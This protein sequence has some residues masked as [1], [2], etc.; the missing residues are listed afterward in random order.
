MISSEGGDE[1]VQH[2]AAMRSGT[3]RAW[4]LGIIAAGIF[5]GSTVAAAP[6]AAAPT[7]VPPEVLKYVPVARPTHIAAIPHVVAAGARWEVV[8]ASVD[9]QD[10]IVGAPDGGLFI[11]QQDSDSVR[12]IAP[13]G[14]QTLY[15]A[16]TH[17]AGALGMGTDHRLWAVQRTAEKAITIVGPEPR[18][19]ARSLPD[20]RPLGRLSDIVVDSAGG[21]WI[22]GSFYYVG[23]D[24]RVSTLP[25]QDIQTNGIALSPDGKTLYVTNETEVIAFDVRPGGATANRRVFG[26]LEGDTSADGMGID[27]AGRVYVCAA[28]GIHV[29]SPE[30]RPLGVI[31]TSTHPTSVAFAGPGKKTLYVVEAGALKSDG[32]ILTPAEGATRPA[33]TLYKLSMLAEGFEGRGK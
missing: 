3:H 30:G 21:A 11:A 15:A 12:K 33:R 26:S 9:L 16:N 7:D 19:I 24:G 5:S 23:P 31:P 13:D 1:T 20:G 25:D 8:Y 14:S 17:G 4:A 18:V 28:S 32:K 27:G 22:S 29:I 2:A 10:G 6:P